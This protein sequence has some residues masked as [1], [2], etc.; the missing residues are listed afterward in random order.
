MS[1]S[2]KIEACAEIKKKP[3]EIEIIGDINVRL[4]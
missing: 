2:K 4:I 3:F 1:K